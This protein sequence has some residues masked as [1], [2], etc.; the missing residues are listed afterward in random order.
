MAK[1]C[2][3]CGAQLDDQANFCDR[4]GAAQNEQAAAQQQHEQKKIPK[5]LMIVIACMSSAIAI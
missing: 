1:Y 2:I 3:K 5:W 4:C